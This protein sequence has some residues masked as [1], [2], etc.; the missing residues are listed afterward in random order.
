MVQFID[1][2]YSTLRKCESRGLTGFS[3]G[4][5]GTWD[6][7]ARYPDLF[8]AAMPICGGG[9]VQQAGKLTKLPIWVF[10]GDA[11]KA[12]PVERSRAMVSAIKQRGGNI[13]Y[14]EYPGVGHDSWTA[15]FSNPE[16]MQWL[17][18]QAR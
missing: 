3:M 18:D 4:G 5:Y 12:V 13:K 2:N 10:H 17:F 8:A 9:D 7:S 1:V 15:T 6:L 11:D 14:T 16:I